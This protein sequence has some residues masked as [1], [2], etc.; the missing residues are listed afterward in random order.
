MV[1]SLKLSNGYNI[2]LFPI[3]TF[4]T[5]SG[6]NV[7]VSNSKK[8]TWIWCTICQKLDK[9]EGKAQLEIITRSHVAAITACIVILSGCVKLLAVVEVQDPELTLYP[10]LHVT[11]IAPS[12]LAHASQ[13][14]TEQLTTVRVIFLFTG[15]VT[16]EIAALTLNMYTVS[17]VTLGAVTLRTPVA[18]LT[19]SNEGSEYELYAAIENEIE[20]DPDELQG[21]SGTKVV[22]EFSIILKDWSFVWKYTSEI[23]PFTELSK[24]CINS[25][26]YYNYL[27]I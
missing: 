5:S 18:E 19:L 27:F 20:V 3:I 7:F 15:P 1:S 2:Q 9:D 17:A 16:P 10:G 22:F 21:K 25:N 12:T 8:N 24:Y 6:I 14:S 11:H 26:K 4:S 23:Y 13:L